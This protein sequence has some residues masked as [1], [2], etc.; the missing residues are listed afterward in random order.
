MLGDVYLYRADVGAIVL[1]RG[2]LI[3][4]G[5]LLL[6]VVS[7]VV[8]PIIR[9]AARGEVTAAAAAPSGD[10]SATGGLDSI[11]RVNGAVG[12]YIVGGVVVGVSIILIKVV[13]YTVLPLLVGDT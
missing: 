6:G 11:G 9:G 10:A 7:S 1:G 8:T 4:L 5:V 12:G 13:I 2:V 3:V